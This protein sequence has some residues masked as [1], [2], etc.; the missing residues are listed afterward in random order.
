MDKPSARITPP[1]PPRERIGIDVYFLGGGNRFF[2]TDKET[3]ITLIE[4][5]AQTETK[6]ICINQT[7][8]NFK[9]VKYLDFY[10]I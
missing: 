3:I 8:I 7:A 4:Q 2:H 6:V 10:G 9:N 1:G 5:M